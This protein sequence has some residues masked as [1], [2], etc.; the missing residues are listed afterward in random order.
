MA[1]EIVFLRIVAALLFLIASVY[2][3]KIYRKTKNRTD[4]WLLITVIMIIG[5]LESGANAFQWGEIFVNTA[6]QV[7]E[8][9]IITSSIIWMYVG[10]KFLRELNQKKELDK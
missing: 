3:W 8:Y 10:Y 2:S 9:L 6:D 5:F 1:L 4:I 7:G